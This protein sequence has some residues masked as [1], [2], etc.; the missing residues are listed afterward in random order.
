M[1]QPKLCSCCYSIKETYFK[2]NCGKGPEFLNLVK[3]KKI[4]QICEDFVTLQIYSGK[5]VSHTNML[6]QMNTRTG[7]WRPSGLFFVTL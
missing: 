1:N 5:I 2:K 4:K 6:Q 3:I 7:R